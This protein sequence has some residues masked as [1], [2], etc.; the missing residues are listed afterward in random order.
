MGREGPDPRPAPRFEEESEEF[1][2]PRPPSFN[3]ADISDKSSNFQAKAA[4]LSEEQIAQL[5][6]DYQGRLGSLL[7]VDE[8]VGKIVRTLRK[9][10]QL[11]NTVIVFLSDNGWLQGEHRIPGDKFLPYDESLR[12]PLVIRGPEVPAG[13]TIEGQVSNIDFAPTL[14]DFADAKAGR[15][16]DGVSLLPSIRDRAP[17]P[18][19]ALE[20][21]APWPL[22]TGAIPVN[23]WDR[24]YKGVRTDRY[25]YV[26]W[27]ET[28]EEE[29][30][31]RREDPYELESVA[32]DPAYADVKADLA[33]KLVELNDCR[34]SACNV[35]P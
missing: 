27:T 26:V 33:A 25:T 11:R 21:E 15:R 3:E 2:L 24:P 5:E 6:L 22:F 10:D 18:D 17:V 34:G 14:L 35:K 13:R 9:T 8:H 32:A 30:Y 16:M 4:P 31:D 29:L 7:A 1:V 20:I 28:G 19:R 23:A 12:I